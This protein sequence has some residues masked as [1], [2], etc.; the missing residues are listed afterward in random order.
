MCPPRHPGA[1][2]QHKRTWAY[3][4]RHGRHPARRKLGRS[5]LS[6]QTPAGTTTAS[7]EAC[8]SC[9]TA[10]GVCQPM[11][12][13]MLL[14]LATG[15]GALQLLSRLASVGGKHIGSAHSNYFAPRSQTHLKH[16][17]LFCERS[18]SF[19]GPDPFERISG[20]SRCI[21]FLGSWLAE[22]RPRCQQ[23]TASFK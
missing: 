21:H 4:A 6:L 12:V 11:S 10:H 7:C 1:A 9:G 16:P 20:P 5:M 15:P 13:L 2:E 23:D 3:S 22:P 8:S 18:A 17:L 14:S 19:F